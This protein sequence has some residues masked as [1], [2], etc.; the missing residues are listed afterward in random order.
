MNKIKKINIWLLHRKIVNL[1][2]HLCVI[3]KKATEEDK[4]IFKQKVK[5]SIHTHNEEEIEKLFDAIVKKIKEIEAKPT[6]IDPGTSKY[7]S[8]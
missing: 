7:Y 8:D 1:Y 3:S 2:D 5:D 6:M 4:K